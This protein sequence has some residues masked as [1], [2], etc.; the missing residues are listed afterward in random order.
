MAK[1]Q[2]KVV[3]VPI[4]PY[5]EGEKTL[6][7]LGEAGWEVVSIVQQ[8]SAGRMVLAFLKSPIPGHR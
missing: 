1:W 7:S 5:W 4:S 3:P 2:Y 6:N 8:D